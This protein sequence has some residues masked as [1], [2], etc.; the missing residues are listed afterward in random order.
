MKSE[1]P[2]SGCL[3]CG[4]RT[5]AIGIWHPNTLARAEMGVSPRRRKVIVYGLC[6]KHSRK[7]RRFM[8]QIERTLIAEI[9]TISGFDPVAN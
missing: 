4:R 2:R 8:E 9:R 1:S 6:R 7:P 3:L 5:V